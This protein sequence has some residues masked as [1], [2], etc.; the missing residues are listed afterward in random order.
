MI[1]IRSFLLNRKARPRAQLGKSPIEM[2]SEKHVDL[3]LDLPFLVHKLWLRLE[4]RALEKKLIG[5]LK[6]PLELLDP[7]PP[8]LAPTV[9]LVL[10]NI[11]RVRVVKIAAVTKLQ[12][13]VHRDQ[14]GMKRQRLKDNIKVNLLF[15][16][17]T[18]LPHRLLPHRLQNESNLER[19]FVRLH[20]QSESNQIRPLILPVLSTKKKRARTTQSSQ[21]R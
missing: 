20:P 7:P 14:K 12:D 11:L 4:R 2:P 17:L 5:I 16:E 15:L 19:L 1:G 21:C 6:E 9:L 18:L 10:R 13:L 8:L 3:D